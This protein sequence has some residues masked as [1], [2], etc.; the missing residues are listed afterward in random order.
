MRKKNIKQLGLFSENKTILQEI[1]TR[2]TKRK[3]FLFSF[4]AKYDSCKPFKSSIEC[5]N[6]MEF[7]REFKTKFTNAL[8]INFN[9]IKNPNG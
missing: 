4:V 9:Q 8:L 5:N 1:K 6:E 2:K 3:L 7:K